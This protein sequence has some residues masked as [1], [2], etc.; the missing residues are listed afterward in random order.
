MMFLKEKITYFV[1]DNNTFVH[2][3]FCSFI[4]QTVIVQK[5]MQNIMLDAP[6]EM[7]CLE[8]G[9]SRISLSYGKFF[10]IQ[11]MR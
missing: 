6:C 9:N 1:M 3:F 11:L 8:K 10:K 4:L 2:S 7:K 5:Y